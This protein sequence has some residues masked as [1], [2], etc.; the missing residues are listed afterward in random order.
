[1]RRPSCAQSMRSSQSSR[2]ASWS[3]VGTAR[4]GCLPFA[5]FTAQPAR[6]PIPN[7]ASA[8]D[9]PP[10]PTKSD[11][12]LH[13]LCS[14]VQLRRCGSAAQLQ[15]RANRIGETIRYDTI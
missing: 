7:I 2:R 13:A 6:E 14:F 8:S 4:V 10:R 3:I 9:L 5:R 1:M 11:A 12:Q 15:R